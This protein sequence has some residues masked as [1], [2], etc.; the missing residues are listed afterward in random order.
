MNV[1][2]KQHSLYCMATISSKVLFVSISCLF[3]CVSYG[4]QKKEKN[5]NAEVSLAQ[6][7]ESVLPGGVSIKT[8][9]PQSAA[10]SPNEGE[11][12]KVQ[13]FVQK[14][15]FLGFFAQ[16]QR[17]LN[18]EMN[19]GQGSGFFVSSDGYLLTN[20][21]VILGAIKVLVQ[22][23]GQNFPVEARV[24][25]EDRSKDLALLKI[26]GLDRRF[27]S[28]KMGRSLRT[29]IGENVFAVGNPF[30]YG[31]T[32]TKGILS[33]KNRRIDKGIAKTFLQTDA[34][35]NPGNSGGPLLNFRGEVIG[36]NSALLS[37]AHGISFSIPSEVALKFVTEHVRPKVR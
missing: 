5:S 15:P 30:G 37:E 21:H 24:V 25:A 22:V 34:S 3:T 29:R 12:Q 10:R 9:L 6:L 27:V 31:N 11:S 19:H 20:H 17:A 2:K 16:P 4:Y 33:A 28:L 36:I 13:G 32:V 18:R 8:T 1:L 26:E 7:V 14:D 35:L 23:D